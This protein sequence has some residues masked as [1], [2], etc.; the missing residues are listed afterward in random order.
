[1]QPRCYF[2]FRLSWLRVCV[3][4][5]LFLVRLLYTFIVCT[6][7]TTV[8]KHC[9]SCSCVLSSV[10]VH[11][12]SSFPPFCQIH[13]HWQQSFAVVFFLMNQD[14]SKIRYLIYVC[15]CAVPQLL[16]HHNLTNWPLATV[17]QMS[18][19]QL[20]PAYTPSWTGQQVVCAC[21]V[22]L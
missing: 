10:Q 18:F 1:M 3:Y 22:P 14:E 20:A 8:L 6:W 15:V 11:L 13:Q 21:V 4:V 9:T 5:L 12:P 17:R 7:Q 16:S 2:P 19:S